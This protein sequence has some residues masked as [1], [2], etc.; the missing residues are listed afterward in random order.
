MAQIVKYPRTTRFTKR[1][2]KQIDELKEWTNKNGTE[3]IE[4]A[5]NLYHYH[6][7]SQQNG[8]TLKQIEAIQ[9]KSANLS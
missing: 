1:S 4:T 6:E 9:P 3:V 2:L 8:K 5:L 7:T